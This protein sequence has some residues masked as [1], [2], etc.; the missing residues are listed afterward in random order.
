MERIN[1]APCGYI[2]LDTKG[3]IKFINRTLL[4]WL[5]REDEI[6]E[7][8]HI[9]SL[10]TNVSQIMFYSYFYPTISMKK[11]VDEML[12]KLTAK[13]GTNKPFVLNARKLLINNEQLIDC[14]FMKMDKR[15]N[16]EKELWQAKEDIKVTLVK[17]EQ[18]FQQLE[19]IYEEIEL[20]Q[21]QLQEMNENL[22]KLSHLDQL[23]GI[24]NRHFLTGYLKEQVKLADENQHVFS[25]VIVDI[26]FFKRV[27]D[28]Y[29][30]LAGDLVL[31]R[32]AVLL[33]EYINEQG[34]VTR[35]GGEEFVII[36]PNKNKEQ[37]IEIANYLNLLVAK[38]V[39]AEVDHITI[40][41]GISTVREGDTKTTIF[42]RADDALYAAKHNGRNQARHIND[43]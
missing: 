15:V 22:K 12:I 16:Y 37:A 2:V 10:L 38:Q 5:D 13:N 4:I 11:S 39:F 40:S 29:G 3:V 32:L 8:R 31:A 6:F 24:Y 17:K 21:L 41:L 7:G 30:H 19:K 25:L 20:K 1:N 42:K 26:D 35:Y 43:L 34:V 28:T 27:N 33:K 14:I 23:T 9:E 18:A 36:L